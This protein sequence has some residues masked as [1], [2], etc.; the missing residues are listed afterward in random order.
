MNHKTSQQATMV[1][2][3]S[4]NFSQSFEAAALTSLSY[5]LRVAY[6]ITSNTSIYAGYEGRVSGDSSDSTSLGLRVSF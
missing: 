6:G 5:G 1:S 3:P 2:T 4:V